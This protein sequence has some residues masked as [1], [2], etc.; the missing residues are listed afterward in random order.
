[1]FGGLV[2]EKW[3]SHSAASYKRPAICARTILSRQKSRQSASLV[4]LAPPRNDLSMH[5]DRRSSTC[6][7]TVVMGSKLMTFSAT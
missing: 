4:W 3:D 7:A 6:L 1:M 2:V 5:V